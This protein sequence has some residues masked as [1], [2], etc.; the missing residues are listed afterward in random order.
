MKKIIGT[1]ILTLT[2]LDASAQEIV[3][4]SIQENCVSCRRM[5]EQTCMLVKQGKEKNFSL[6]YDRIEGFTHVPGHQYVLDVELI[7]RFPQAQDLSKYIY[8]LKQVISDKV[9]VSTAENISYQVVTM[10]GR[11]INS[12]I[13]FQF[14]STATKLAGKSGCN[15]FNTTIKLTK[16]RNK[17]SIGKGATTMMSCLE[18]QMKDETEFSASVFGKKFKIQ[19]T[20]DHLIFV[21]KGKQI[22]VAVP[23]SKM[24][25]EK[26]EAT[27]GRP[28]K[29]AWNYFNQRELKLIQMDGK[30]LE[31]SRASIKF[32]METSTFYGSNG[33][34]RISGKI[35]GKRNQVA[36]SD[37][38]STKMACEPEIMKQENRFNQILASKG[39]TVDFAE[40][41]LNIYDASGNLVLMFAVLE[42]N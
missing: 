15:R 18:E 31:N 19:S 22:I 42:E 4:M 41:V 27:T 9:V 25:E 35:M 13:T 2:L 14:D 24:E 3:R 29:T 8:K 26:V 10:N 39:L 6:F 11:K 38:V 17:I 23:V 20:A 40:T 28:E 16:K 21:S 5:M 34:N 7:E 33:C 1:L 12:E 36:F 30:T 37:V 32:D